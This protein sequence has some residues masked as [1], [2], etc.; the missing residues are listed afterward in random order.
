MWKKPDRVDTVQALECGE[1]AGDRLG[2]EEE[3]EGDATVASE[4]SD[5]ADNY[6]SP[7]R[8]KSF[9]QRSWHPLNSGSKSPSG[10]L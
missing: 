8:D 9:H 4:S 1:Q 6:N 2:G 10:L 5:D 3:R 7:E